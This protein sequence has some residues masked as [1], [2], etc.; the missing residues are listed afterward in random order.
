MNIAEIVNELKKDYKSIVRH[1][2]TPL[3]FFSSEEE[4]KKALYEIFTSLHP[5]KKFKYTA[6]FENCADYFLDTKGK[7]LALLGDYGTGKTFIISD[8]LR[9]LFYFKY[10]K[11]IRPI[12]AYDIVINCK[13]AAD[14]YNQQFLKYSIIMID[15]LGN[16][17]V[18]NDFGSKIEML[19]LIIDK[20]EDENKL[21]FLTSNRTVKEIE[22][23]YG[24]PIFDRIREL[25]EIKFFK[26]NS[27]RG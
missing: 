27:L 16:E 1:E 9:L 26:G 13:S 10:R 18:F 4:Y 3:K 7:G 8:F 23:R 22:E 11:I 24:K 2:K 21:L 5:S 19:S 12:K 14:L 6:N 20:C 15:E 17:P 25:C